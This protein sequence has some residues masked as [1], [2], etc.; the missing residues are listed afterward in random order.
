MSDYCLLL[1]YVA[2]ILKKNYSFPLLVQ[3][4]QF[5]KGSVKTE[6]SRENRDKGRGEGTFPAAD[7]SSSIDFG[8]FC[9]CILSYTFETHMSQILWS[10]TPG[11]EA[12]LFCLV[13]LFCF[14]L[15][16]RA[17]ITLLTAKI[18]V[19]VFFLISILH[20]TELISSEAV[21]AIILICKISSSF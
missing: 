16:I 7:L 20:L 2:G 10:L 18:S 21:N 12:F 11:N 3:L 13:S 17:I 6:G 8:R 19:Q 1:L 14:Y 15:N 9:F 4:W 5:C